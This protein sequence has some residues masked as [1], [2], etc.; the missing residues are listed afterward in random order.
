[1]RKRK[2]RTHKKQNKTAKKKF[3]KQKQD[4]QLKKNNRMTGFMSDL[5]KI[6][7]SS[8]KVNIMMTLSLL[9]KLRNESTYV[10]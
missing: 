9:N 8:E 4:I 3:K 2:K 5:K 6:K 7:K 10:Y 1:M